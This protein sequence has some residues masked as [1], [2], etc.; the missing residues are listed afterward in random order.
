MPAVYR[1]R[2]DRGGPPLPVW[3]WHRLAR[4]QGQAGSQH[5]VSAGPGTPGGLEQIRQALRVADDRRAPRSAPFKARRRR[6]RLFTTAP[7]Q[8]VPLVCFRPMRVMA[9]DWSGAQ[10]GLA[11]KDLA[12]RGARGALS[13]ARMWAGPSGACGPSSFRRSEGSK[14]HC[15]LR[16]RFLHARMVPDGARL[17]KRTRVVATLCR[18]GR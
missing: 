4:R 1:G 15:R 7:S 11:W 8:F 12:C 18:R 10:R 5:P 9:V 13:E 6:A 16:L 17:L 2:G 14:P 3:P